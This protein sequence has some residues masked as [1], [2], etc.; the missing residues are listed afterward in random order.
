MG[1]VGLEMSNILSTSTNGFANSSNGFSF[2][3]TNTSGEK[4]YLLRYRQ[5]IR[6]GY[7]YNVVIHDGSGNVIQSTGSLGTFNAT[8]NYD[9][10]EGY[11][12][13]E[14]DLSSNPVVVNPSEQV[15]LGVSVNE[16][17]QI[18]MNGV[19]SSSDSSFS[20]DNIR[21]RWES[22]TEPG[23]DSYNAS[24]N[25]GECGGYLVEYSSTPPSEPV[26]GVFNT[27]STGR[28]G[29]IQKFTVPESGFYRIES[30]GAQGGRGNVT[31][32]THGRD[33]GGRGAYVRGDFFLEKGEEVNV[34]VGQRGAKGFGN[35][36]CGGAGGGG[37][38]VYKGT[39]GGDGLMLAAGGG[40]GGAGDGQFN[41]ERVHG[42]AQPNG[43]K[44]G[45]GTYE[46]T[47][48][49]AE[50]GVDGHGGNAATQGDY[51]GGG[52]TGWYSDG[53][54]GP[55]NPGNGGQRFTGGYYRAAQ[56]GFG[57]GAGTGDSR[58]TYSHGAGGGGGFSGGGGAYYSTGNGGGG[59]SYLSGSN[60]LGLDGTN[61]GHG[62]VTFTK[63]KN[64]TGEEVFSHSETTDTSRTGNVVNW[65]VPY[66]G[67][68]FIE[69]IG[70]SGGDGRR[71]SSDDENGQHY[72]GNGAYMSGYFEL[73]E[74]E[75]LKILVGKKGDT[76]SDDN[77]GAGGGGGS[78]VTKSDN[79]PLLVAG[80]GGGASRSSDYSHMDGG[81]APTTNDGDRSGNGGGDYGHGQAAGFSQNSPDGAYSFTNGGTGATEDG[82]NGANGGFGGAASNT[83]HL[84]GGGGGYTGGDGG[85]LGYPGM[86]STG[87]GSYNAGESQ[88]NIEGA[89]FGSGGTVTIYNSVQK[90]DGEEDLD[91]FININYRSN[92][93]SSLSV[94]REDE[95]DKESMLIVRRSNYTEIPSSITNRQQ[96]TSD[97]GMAIRVNSPYVRE[98]GRIAKLMKSSINIISKKASDLL[99]KVGI[100]F[101]SR[102]LNEID[103]SGYD[104][105]Q[106]SGS[107]NIKTTN[108]LPGSIGVKP[109]NKMKGIVDVQEPERVL[110]SFNPVADAYIRSSVARLNYGEYEMLAAGYSPTRAEVF[111]SLLRF[112]ISD[113][114]NLPDGFELEHAKLKLKYAYEP[115]T[116]DIKLVMV[117][118][119]WDELGVTWANR[120]SE[121]MD[122]SVGYELL[123]D[124]K[125]VEIDLTE[126]VRNLTNYGV[127]REVNFYLVNVNEG[128]S[129]NYFYS[130]DMVDY[131][132]E[133][134][135]TY[136]DTRIFSQGRA[137][138]ES[139]AFIY[140]RGNGDLDS[141]LNVKGYWEDL[142]IGGSINVT[143]S[144]WRRS[145]LDSKF[146]VTQPHL[147]SNITSRQNVD[148]DL[149]SSL[150][151]RWTD[152]FE[153]SEGYITVSKPSMPS[154]IY[155][156]Y[157]LDIPSILTKRVGDDS[158]K[159]GF[160]YVRP[161]VFLPG[162]LDVYYFDVLPSSLRTKQLEK[163]ELDSSIQITTPSKVSSI[164]VKYY[165]SLEGSI[166]SR[167]SDYTEI[168]STFITSKPFIESS[169]YVTPY[170][171][172]PMSVR[173]RRE[174][175]SNIS[176]K[177]QT[178]RPFIFGSIQPIIHND[179]D[180]SIAVRREDEFDKDSSLIIPN[181]LDMDS[182]MFI[183]GASMLPSSIFALSPYLSSVIKVPA[184]DDSDLE[185]V[186]SARQ[187]DY[188]DISSVIAPMIHNSINSSITVNRYA[189]E[190]LGGNVTAR[191]SN[192]SDIDG[193]VNV[194]QLSDLEGIIVSRQRTEQDLNSS[195][196]SAYTDE[197]EAR[198][199]VRGYLNIPSSIKAVF[200]NRH[201][202]E[203]SILPRVKFFND[204]PTSFKAVNRGNDYV[205]S[206]LTILPENRMKG[207]VD[208]VPPNIVTDVNEPVKDSYVRNEVPK[209]N[210]GFSQTIAVGK[211]NSG[212]K[213]RTFLGF[214]IT[215]IPE[216]Q[217]INKATLRLSYT[218]YPEINLLLKETGSNWE[219]FGIT[220]EN[221]PDGGNLVKDSFSVNDSEQYIEFDLTDYISSKYAKEEGLLDFLLRQS[222]EDVESFETFFTKESDYAPVLEVQYFTTEIPSFGRANRKSSI[223]VRYRGNS[224]ITGEIVVKKIKDKDDLDS[225]VEVVPYGIRE[226]DGAIEVSAPDRESTL[227][228]RRTTESDLP[229]SISAVKYNVTE[230]Q[231]IVTV[232][233]SFALS[234]LYVKNREDIEGTLTIKQTESYDVYSYGQVIAKER[235]ASIRVTPTSDIPSSV[236]ARKNIPDDIDS[237]IA[238]SRDTVSGNL[239]VIPATDLES[240][241]KVSREGSSEIDS[242]ITVSKGSLPSSFFVKYEFDIP[243]TLGIPFNNKEDIDTKLTVNKP[244]IDS[245]FYILHRFDFKGEI[246]V[247]GWD[248]TDQVSTLH[249]SRDTAK[250]SFE[251]PER[252]DKEST[253][254]VR[255]DGKDSLDSLLQ[256]SNP[257][258]PSSFDVANRVD[259]DS[260]LRVRVW[261]EDD[262]EMMFH[263]SKDFID[264]SIQPNIH[265]DLGASIEVRQDGEKILPSDLV[266][267]KPEI[268]GFIKINGYSVLPAEIKVVMPEGDYLEGSLS[269]SKPE[270]PSN[271]TARVYFGVQL[272][273][274]IIVTE[275]LDI[276]STV[277][278]RQ[279]SN[280][281]VEG[282]LNVRVEENTDL[283]SKVSVRVWK[284]ADK[285]SLLNV[286]RDRLNGSIYIYPYS[287]IESSIEVANIG[288]LDIPS[289]LGVR[290]RSGLENDIHI[291]GIGDNDLQGSVNVRSVSDLDSSIL[292]IHTDDYDMP[293]KFEVRES[294][295][296]E[297]DSSIYIL[298]SEDNDFEGTI[299]VKPKNKMKGKVF[300]VPVDDSDLS[301]VI[302]AHEINEID[303]IITARQFGDSDLPVSIVIHEVSDIPSSITARQ[304]D[305]SDLD[306]SIVVRQDDDYDM[307]SEIAARQSD[308][309]EIGG[310]ITARQLETS[311]I[312]GEVVARQSDESDLDSW[313]VV[314]EVYDITECSI[315]VR[316]DDISDIDG[317]ITV[318]QS[319][320]SDLDG[321]ITVRQ[322][323]DYDMPSI[324]WPRYK[325]EIDGSIYILY[326]DDLNA[327]I[328]VITAYPYAFIM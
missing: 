192:E 301:S 6:D 264:S 12:Y 85:Y 242:N 60:Q 146:T 84:G 119:Q 78:F 285:V 136:F 147:V 42:T 322:S 103:I 212:E 295:H 114:V 277:V 25:S 159:I 289:R 80:G 101:N 194:Y 187:S 170:V 76:P 251:I 38:F 271:I 302:E 250:F 90:E 73:T 66:D 243:S 164:Y 228:V 154:S 308:F 217:T 87:G 196:Y 181:R 249:V 263:V 133:F 10:S 279:T 145:S 265:S 156:P 52:G 128:Q 245:S 261:G 288:K 100:R 173:V 2:K 36:N 213:F 256:V 267:S 58:T 234:S 162:S 30:F 102:L 266:I 237:F 182:E 239:K 93:H 174:D 163:S 168:D 77:Q 98:G 241:I 112:D 81:H 220:W 273:S 238:V 79:T 40:G 134:N 55:D 286:N 304:D 276:P 152:F 142:D 190:D 235:P 275:F 95:Q 298:Y 34:V 214:D 135:I 92:L 176:V 209:L 53:E 8:K 323:D 20:V 186:L 225:V 107:I 37:S 316:Q 144:G 199:R 131:E 169:A 45:N 48:Y 294:D 116:S 230:I 254:H 65:T 215:D 83:E 269:I 148:H 68:F 272:P 171:D 281:D 313:I 278:S 124:D 259:T 233:R 32:T 290:F 211:Q 197:L 210:Y 56:G 312:D 94:K 203:G 219:E 292:A 287:Q 183:V 253:L 113:Y 59:G 104:E 262:L 231:S 64:Q 89:N 155:P 130:R 300:I 96:T 26:K 317:S 23:T 223:D 117:D 109:Y 69:A 17:A 218:N 160:I 31:P 320:E 232:H 221:Q 195:I 284:D 105:T 111:K 70:A 14:I 283:D 158:E 115:P 226:L 191:R 47:S 15:Y 24:E 74:G 132:P 201:D 99:S 299:G 328:E 29:D 150:S 50:G 57:G 321:S 240:F 106:I 166:T 153:F 75:E 227:E 252:E 4:R 324:V 122:V 247:N 16:Y 151:V 207:I 202:V 200:P 67:R 167:Q 49:S 126:F 222:N 236:N 91:C 123:E 33:N 137:N 224:E 157:R 248:F 291:I 118:G 51:Q 179:L 305:I 260:I 282:S 177:L 22:N 280:K 120:P 21:Y 296:E 19:S 28:N 175:D 7:N 5:Y 44:G 309:S 172:F 255:V 189:D 327:L 206:S 325:T 315:T 229:S 125:S 306:G 319:D 3:F 143:P 46:S 208:I 71:N 244:T 9:S 216:G 129:V 43:R 188:S 268:T 41:G 54:S 127:D 161:Y 246:G 82:S 193:S 310:S 97:V 141:S 293:S 27:T 72:G 13:V 39:I 62:K 35:D 184:Y 303:G 140:I 178:G 63:L 318:R 149:P 185:G 274:S 270:V 180:G 139:E 11:R 257:D 205:P 61:Y 204:L 198:I 311:D 108:E 138:L 165:E 326:H 110:S 1:M 307:P 258:L 88:S 18:G 314:H 86:Y 297:I 121:G